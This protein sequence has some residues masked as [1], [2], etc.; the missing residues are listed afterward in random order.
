MGSLACGPRTFGL[1]IEDPTNAR[2]PDHN[3]PIEI[4]IEVPIEIPIEIGDFQRISQRN[5]HRQRSE[6]PST[7]NVCNPDH[8]IPIEI[9][10]GICKEINLHQN[11]HRN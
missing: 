3:I 2:N 7:L 6:D 1:R 10:T 4:L 5:S 8:N 11:S 9:S